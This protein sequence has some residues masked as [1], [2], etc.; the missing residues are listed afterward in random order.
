MDLINENTLKITLSQEVKDHIKDKIFVKSEMQTTPFNYSICDQIF[1]S[2]YYEEILNHLPSSDK[3]FQ[4]SDRVFNN[5]LRLWVGHN[6]SIKCDAFKNKCSLCQGWNGN[7]IRNDSFWKEL[8]EF[9]VSD[10][11]LELWIKKYE[12]LLIERH[13]DKF[14]MLKEKRKFTLSGYLNRDTNGYKIGPHL[15]TLKKSITIIIY[16]PSTDELKEYGTTL[17]KPK[18]EYPKHKGGHHEFD[19]F[20]DISMIECIPNRC[21]DFLVDLNSWHC[22]HEIKK[23]IQRNSIQLNIYHV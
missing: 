7:N 2:D 19:K 11:M 17:C 9:L 1:P 8:L 3:Y 4:D 15:D 20:T 16:L 22:V 13:K 23:D 6:E 14:E 12:K 21:A 5:R 18:N 10:E